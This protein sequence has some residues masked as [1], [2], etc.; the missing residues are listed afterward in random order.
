[1]RMSAGG[2]FVTAWA[3]VALAIPGCSSKPT[4]AECEQVADKLTAIAVRGENPGKGEA[5]KELLEGLR[6]QVIK[7]CENKYSR[8]K[9]RCLIRAE[10]KA[11][12]DA[13]G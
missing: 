10:D 5:L 12:A 7:T 2:I 9:A 8:A 1:M 11:Q 4:T 3:L 6:P 13:C